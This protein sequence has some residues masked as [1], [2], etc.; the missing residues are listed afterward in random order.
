MYNNPQ[1][2]QWPYGPQAPNVVFVPVPAETPT[3]RSR[4]RGRGRSFTNPN[5]LDTAIDGIKKQVEAVE[6]FQEEQK[7]KYKSEPPKKKWPDWLTGILIATAVS[8]IIGIVSSIFFF[9]KLVKLMSVM[10]KPL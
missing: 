4:G 2:P 3:T 5:T 10:P 6:R 1:Y 9:E 8:P 7:K